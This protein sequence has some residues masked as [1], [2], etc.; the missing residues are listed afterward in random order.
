MRK[1]SMTG[2]IG[3]VDL[4]SSRPELPSYPLLLELYPN[5]EL[6]G[7]TQGHP[8]NNLLREIQLHE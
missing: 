1:H 8:Y 7:D 3:F 2:K 5:I 6:S 4:Y